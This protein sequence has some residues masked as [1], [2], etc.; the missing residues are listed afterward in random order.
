M[1]N[2]YIYDY[3]YIYIYVQMMFNGNKQSVGDGGRRSIGNLIIKGNQL[4]TNA[5]T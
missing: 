5:N 1:Y 4:V 3:V 2:I